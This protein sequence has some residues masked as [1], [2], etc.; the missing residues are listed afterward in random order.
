MV[1]Y[2]N[3]YAI[4]NISEDAA[5]EEIKSAFRKLALIHHPDKND[6]S[7]ESEAQFIV[8][9][10]AY[11]VLS[12]PLKRKEYDTYL[13]T[14]SVI[15]AWKKGSPDVKAILSNIEEKEGDS[16]ETISSHLNFLLW[17]IEDFLRHTGMI[18][19]NREKLRHTD[20][21]VLDREYN[22]KPLSEY[23]LKIL[24]F[25]D[26]WILTRV[27]YGDHFLKA[28]IESKAD[29]KDYFYNI[30]KRMDKFLKNVVV[31]DLL[32]TIPDSKIRII[33]C[34]FEAQNHTVH[35]LCFM[36]Q[37]LIGEIED[38]PP[39]KHSNDCYL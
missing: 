6:N 1:K 33:D 22:G 11:T 18:F 29:I 32:E 14:S 5:L 23:V 7:P 28:Y 36:N 20:L 8:I 16:L 10:N 12:D 27:G 17:D 9:Q 34:I 2:S 39:F 25:I 26:K 35:Y 30:R 13:R 4:L 15:K 3:L 37:A 31:N 19:W 24:I 38:I 21:S